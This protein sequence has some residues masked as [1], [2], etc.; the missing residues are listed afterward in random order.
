MRYRNEWRKNLRLRATVAVCVVACAFASGSG[1]YV[2]QERQ[3]RPEQ[4]GSA[5]SSGAAASSGLLTEVMED[6][7]I[8]PG[9]VVD[10]QVDRAAELS[11]AYH[12]SA[13]G[14]FE[15]TYLGQVPARDRTREE[16]VNLITVG[17]KGGYLK[18]PRVTITIKRQPP[19]RSTLYL[20]G[21]FRHP[22]AYQV[23]GRPSFL[24]LISIAGGLE[25]DY[26]S[27]AF[28]FRETD[29]QGAGPKATEG[30]PGLT[31]TRSPSESAG[32]SEARY[33]MHM[34]NV[35]DLLKGDLSQDSTIKSGDI[36][37]IPP[38]DMFFVAGEVRRPGAFPLR[39][40]TTLSQAISLAEGP[41][42][43]AA[44]SA[45]ILRIDQQTRRRLQIE[46]RDI[47]AIMKGTKQDLAIQADDIV[48]IPNSKLKSVANVLLTGLGASVRVPFRY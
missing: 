44:G 48:T 28:I 46:V 38:T 9:D 17:L 12:V 35:R 25:K 34:V 39:E 11:G 7:R 15:M 47:R 43:K 24:K 40:G 27:T 36:I 19:S 5:T 33:E 30:V 10:I 41:T 37:N 2:A 14:T 31:S 20:Q 23:E 16:L 29:P 18:N 8:S 6:Y 42:F 1:G 13:A 21:S 3:P 45:T 4:S 26:G 22:G 32:E